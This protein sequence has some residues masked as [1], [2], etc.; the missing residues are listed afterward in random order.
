[1]L[2]NPPAGQTAVERRPNGDL[3]DWRATAYDTCLF[4]GSDPKYKDVPDNRLPLDVIEVFRS[5]GIETLKMAMLGWHRARK[6]WNRYGG[7]TMRE[8][9]RDKQKVEKG[10]KR[11]RRTRAT[12]LVLETEQGTVVVPIVGPGS[13]TS[14][15]TTT[16]AKKHDRKPA[17]TGP[18]MRTKVLI[19]PSAVVIN[20]SR[21][22]KLSPEVRAEIKR[23]LPESSIIGATVDQIATRIRARSHGLGARAADNTIA[24]LRR[25]CLWAVPDTPSLDH[26]RREVISL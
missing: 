1:M 14:V 16:P 22:A 6:G 5:H 13:K 25:E 4:L 26:V 10:S 7:F 24:R 20:K 8:P 2:V 18:D 19:D 17:Y 12:E 11:R 21:L 15:S 3:Y 9:L 23:I